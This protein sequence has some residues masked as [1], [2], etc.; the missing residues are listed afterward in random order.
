MLR[1]WLLKWL[2]MCWCVVSVLYPAS[3]QAD[4][5][6][7]S[8]SFD[9]AY[10]A[11]LALTSQNEAEKSKQS[12]VRLNQAWQSYA[13]I[14]RAYKPADAAWKNGFADIDSA[15]AKADAQV[16]RGDSLAAAHDTLEPVRVIL[17]QL[18]RKN[19]I[20][21]YVDYQTAF[22]EP[23]E[24]AVL[25]AKGKTADTLTQQDME[26][27]RRLIPTLEARWSALQNAK[28]EAAQF[29]FDAARNAKLRHYSELETLAIAAL[30]RALA[31]SDKAAIIQRALA[32]KPPFA[33]MFMLFGDLG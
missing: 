7:D 23:M 4:I 14:Y 28:F 22:H 27:M 18:R 33:Q 12:M 29:G 3:A 15:I 20:D 6:V 2:L 24:E 19:G 32:I 26:K 21:Y 10:I 1:K 25:T 30:K 16:T 17:M 9:K 8:A 31:E 13:G 5:V 11:A